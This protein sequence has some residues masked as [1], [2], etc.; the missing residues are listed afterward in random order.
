VPAGIRLPEA[1]AALRQG[2]AGS[3]GRKVLIVLDQFEQWLHARREREDTELI[4]ALRQC[5]GERLQCLVLVRDDFWMAVTRFLRELEVRLVEGQNSAP[6]DLFPTRHAEKVLAAFGRA[7]AAL[8]DHAHETTKEQEKFLS[9]AVSG[10]AQEGNVSCIRL[11]LLAEVVKRKPWTPATLTDVGGT[12]GVGVTFL[13]ET[14]SAA[15]APPQHRMHQEAARAVLQ[16]LLP[17]PGTDIKSHVWSLAHLREASGYADRPRDFE[18]LLR[19]LDRETRLI[20]PAD[21][22]AVGECQ[23]PWPVGGDRCYQLTHDYLVPA[24]REWLTRK[25]KETRRGRAELRLAERAAEWNARPENR[26]LP[27]W[28]EWATIRLLTRKKGWTPAQGQMMRRAARYHAVRE[29]VLAV[30][31]VL[32]ALA[33]WETFGRVKAH[34]LRDRLLESTTA[35]VP[36]IVRDMAPYRR[37]VDPL[38]QEAYTQAQE[39]N[40]ARKQLHASLALLPVDPGQVAYLR[41]HLLQAGPEEVTVIRQAL[42]DSRP[43]LIGP[44][45]SV[46]EDR[47]NDQDQRFRAACALA[48]YDADS[49]RWEGVSEDVAAKLVVQD[50]FV[51]A[52]W[53]A[54]LRPVRRFLLPPLATF[55]E[56]EKRSGPERALIA[57]VYGNY[58]EGDPAAISRL[59]RRLAEPSKPNAPAEAKLVLVKRQAN[60]AVALLVMGRGDK[61]WPLL[62]HSPDPTL[63]SFLI[64]RLGPGGVAPK[65][66]T[67][68]LG[69][70]PEVSIRR[71]IL[72]SLGGYGLDRLPQAERDNLVPRLTRLYR[73]DPDPGVH[74]AAEWVLRCWQAE[75]KI[76]GVNREPAAGEVKDGRRWYV[77]RQG[78][79]MVI[80]AGPV[81]FWMGEGKE[82]YK[83]QLNRRYAIASKEVTVEEYLR[84]RKDHR[85]V[86]TKAPLGDCPVN[87]VT[88]WEAAAYCNW[89]SKR[90][91]IPE[92]Q[93]CYLPNKEGKYEEGMRMAPDWLR[94][95]G[96]RL[97]TEA[98]WEFACRA[99]AETDYCFGFPEELLGQYAWYD[100]N[101]PNGPHLVASAK[102][103]DLGLFDM[104]GSVWEWTQSSAPDSLVRPGDGKATDDDKNE[105]IP[106]GIGRV[107]RGGSFKDSAEVVRSAHRQWDVP[108]ARQVLV[109]FRPARTIRGE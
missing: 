5:D 27:A 49:P 64:E 97:P 17:E 73:D 87:A 78:Q 72:L 38:L 99:G 50:P 22:E 106:M 14:F 92:D 79:T 66:L 23:P 90:E 105:T 2:R 91:G 100:R 75:A 32:L 44:L 95:A 34:T 46:V 45:W 104:H 10:L 1:L 51:L 40:D 33:G 61:V 9:Q 82:K 85:Y 21:P 41:R 94:R 98:E 18:D 77:N 7:L 31:L 57:K 48:G 25:Q 88:W 15:T 54:A 93:W 65:D 55:L 37:W 74:G 58:A 84:F 102:P 86:G 89:L 53:T 56:D 12:E 71:A 13:E 69:H 52:R 108:L 3:A 35:D 24:L 83:K 36:A 67:A 28:W 47:K 30:C 19:I 60:V 29:F 68:R 62:R 39:H 107:L 101:S 42:F 6:V 70:E 4:Q 103:N 80:V 76:K 81:E 26:H 16:T 96:Y 11:A 59:E 43:A 8:P 20:T 63:R 109:G